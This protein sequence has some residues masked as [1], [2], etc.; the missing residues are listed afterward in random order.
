MSAI[1]AYMWEKGVYKVNKSYLV[2]GYD[3]KR[4]KLSPRAKQLS[5]FTLLAPFSDRV[6]RGV[7]PP[8]AL[9]VLRP[10]PAK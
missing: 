2:T 3:V 10:L 8:M 4:A 7:L 1:G 5:V 6:S 9:E